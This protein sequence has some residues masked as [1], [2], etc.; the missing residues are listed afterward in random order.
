MAATK[1]SYTASDL[2][3]QTVY[4]SL[5]QSLITASAIV[6]DVQHLYSKGGACDVWM[7]DALSAG[8]ETIL[9]GVIAAYDAAD[10]VK[11]RTEQMLKQKVL[12]A[13][14]LDKLT[15]SSTAAGLVIDTTIAELAIDDET[16]VVADASLT[17]YVLISLCY[18]DTDGFHVEAYEKTDGEYDTIE[19]NEYAVQQD[20]S[21]WSVVAN[22]DTLVEVE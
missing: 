12:P 9:D 15:V 20:I 11:F 21:E 16:T 13:N 22:G 7:V 14:F 2:S 5:L 4:V 19:D 18:N 6:T 8:D 17:K 10:Q 3:N 1:Y